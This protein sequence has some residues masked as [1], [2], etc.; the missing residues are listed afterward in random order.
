MLRH[1]T[2]R[3]HLAIQ[4]S[5]PIHSSRKDKVNLARVLG[6][7]KGEVRLPLPKERVS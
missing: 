4:L 2:P 7:A 6:T 5:P 3:C 1:N